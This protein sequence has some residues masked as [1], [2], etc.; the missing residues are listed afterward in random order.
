[1]SALKERLLDPAT[2]PALVKDCVALIDDR[3]RSIKGFTGV[4]VKGGYATVKAIKTGF[5]DGVVDALLD[6]WMAEMTSFEDEFQRAAA[7]PERFSAFL[8]VHR[9]RVAEA[10]IT[11]TDRRAETTKHKTA[12]SFYYRLR[13]SA[14]G[15]VDEAIPD[16][17]GL[18]VRHGGELTRPA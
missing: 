13:K 14:L 11:V 5:V 17:V 3:V 12:A 9:T 7:G 18:L 6:E 1:M 16:L 4:A 8:V 15:H 10:L 2:R